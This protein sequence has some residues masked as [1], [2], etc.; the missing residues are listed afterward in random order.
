MAGFSTLFETIMSCSVELGGNGIIH[1]GKGVLL[2]GARKIGW[3]SGGSAARQGRRFAGH[4]IARKGLAAGGTRNVRGSLHNYDPKNDYKHRTTDPYNQAM[5]CGSGV[6][7][8]RGPQKN[9]PDRLF[10]RP[11]FN[12]PSGPL[13]RELGDRFVRTKDSRGST[14]SKN[15]RANINFGR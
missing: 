11:G 12:K 6:M 10:G 7:R 14:W 5:K 4:S 2:A 13:G 3:A 9:T 8:F 15:P 1:G